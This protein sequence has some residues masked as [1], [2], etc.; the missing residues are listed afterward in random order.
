MY[1]KIIIAGNLGADPVMKYTSDGKAVTTFSLATSSGSGE[2][3]ATTWFRCTV[4]DK[5]AE[6][7]SEHLHSGSKVLVEGRLKP[8]E[9]G[10]PRVFQRKDGTWGASFEVTVDSFRFLDSKQDEVAV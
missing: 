4:W 2:K 3:K 9:N 1:Q 8:D 5:Q 7:A 6:T 10:N